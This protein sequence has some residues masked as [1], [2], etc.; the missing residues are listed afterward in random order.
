MCCRDLGTSSQKVLRY[1][2]GIHNLKP[3]QIRLKIEKQ[4]NKIK[5]WVEKKGYTLKFG[6]ADY[7]DYSTKEV[8]VFQNQYNL[9]HQIYSALHECGHVIIGNSSN[10]YR[11]FK[12]IVKADTIDG[13]HYRSNLYKY[14]KLKEEIDAWEKGYKLAKKLGI[15]INKDDY[16]KYAAKYFVTYC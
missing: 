14:K 12:S 5:N 15:S 10:Y 6:K 3:K 16:D 1:L 7:V 9:K 8:V 4:F 11:D 2:V 13:R